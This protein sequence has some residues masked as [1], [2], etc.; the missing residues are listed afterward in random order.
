[1]AINNHITDP[2]TELKA[3]VRQ[4]G[5]LITG[6]IK[7]SLPF[8]ATLGLNDVPVNIVPAKVGHVFH[9]TDILLDGNK[10]IDATTAATV[11]IYTAV[12]DTTSTA[13]TT[14]LTGLVPKNTSKTLTGIFLEAEKGRRINAV[15]S[16][17]DVVVNILGYYLEVL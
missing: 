1:M 3:K 6:P 11:S 17:D 9:I 8:N 10:N 2:S 7:P 5:A 13:I 14:L 4:G 12:N 15:T 16:D